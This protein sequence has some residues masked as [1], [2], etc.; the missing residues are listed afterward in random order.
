MCGVI[1]NAVELRLRDRDCTKGSRRAAER[2]V[3]EGAPGLQAAMRQKGVVAPAACRFRWAGSPRGPCN[4]VIR[5]AHMVTR[6][7]C[8]LPPAVCPTSLFTP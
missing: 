1:Q 6:V 7:P 5:C 4:G 8:S 3:Q 2:P